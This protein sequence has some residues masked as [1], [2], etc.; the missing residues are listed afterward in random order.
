[1]NYVLTNSLGG[2]RPRKNS[3]T[4]ENTLRYFGGHSIE[5]PSGA[6]GQIGDSLSETEKLK[7]LRDREIASHE[8]FKMK[9]KV[10]SDGISFVFIPERFG[11]VFQR[12]ATLAFS[13]NKNVRGDFHFY[14]ITKNISSHSMYSLLCHNNVMN[15]YTL[16]DFADFAVLLKERGVKCL[17]D[18]ATFSFFV[19]SDSNKPQLFN[20]NKVHSTAEM[21]LFSL[22]IREAKASAPS[23]YKGE[24]R[25]WCSRLFLDAPTAEILPKCSADS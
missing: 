22:Q 17:D 16:N 3:H 14:D 12:Y 20:V 19:K 25:F 23:T 1:M 4:V 15:C 18:E 5:V 9:P 8:W 24:K 2:R 6:T 11:R 10:N 13:T 21:N 7:Q